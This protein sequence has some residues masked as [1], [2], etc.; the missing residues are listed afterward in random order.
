[1]IKKYRDITRMTFFGRNDKNSGIASSIYNGFDRN[2]IIQKGGG[3]SN[4]TIEEPTY[5]ST[6]MFMANPSIILSANGFMPTTIINNTVSNYLIKSVN[7]TAGGNYTVVPDVYLDGTS[8]GIDITVN[9]TGGYITYFVLN[10]AGNAIFSTPPDVLIVGGGGVGATA[11]V[12]IDELGKIS[13]L[14]VILGATT[15]TYATNPTYY[16]INGGVTLTPNLTATAITSI[17]VNNAG[18]Y[19]TSNTIAPVLYLTNWGRWYCNFKFII[20]FI[21]TFSNISTWNL[22]KSTLYII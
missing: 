4:L 16:F 3:V 10:N 19:V 20:I 22:S 21:V 9:I 8:L 12:Q 18:F 6:Y 7:V 15:N 2:L 13:G 11:S 17:T 1:M 5:D 14:T